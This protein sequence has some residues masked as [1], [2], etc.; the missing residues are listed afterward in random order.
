MATPSNTT[1]SQE[2]MFWL[3]QEPSAEDV[4]R[5]EAFARGEI[6]PDWASR[7]PDKAQAK[8]IDLQWEDFTK[9][10][11]PLEDEMLQTYF[12]NGE[13][14]AQRAGLHMAQT[15]GPAEGAVTDTQRELG[16]YGAGVT[17]RQAQA[18][19]QQRG[20]DAARG[21]A[22]AENTTRRQAKDR[23]IEGLGTMMGIGRGI[24]GSA[25]Q[26]MGQAASMAAQR[27]QAGKAAAHS[28]RQN[29]MGNV[30]SGAGMGYMVGQGAAVGGP[31][32]AAIGAGLGLATSL[33]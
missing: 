9:R 20:L 3:F 29:T 33:L 23:N 24:Q 28:Q 19:T 13:P 2:G 15:F 11:R 7:R 12:G 18:L 31:W 30:V 6:D 8:L 10:F 21:I 26:N 27:E 25:Q 32:G 5:D 17:Q 14:E 1:D 22:T 4:R 16:R